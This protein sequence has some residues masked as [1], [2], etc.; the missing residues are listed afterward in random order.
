MKTIKKILAVII[1]ASLFI[2][3]GCQKSL[4]KTKEEV[5]KVISMGQMEGN[6]Y[7][8]VV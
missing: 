5:K 4:E 8:N 1:V 2:M 3:A 6:T 7:S